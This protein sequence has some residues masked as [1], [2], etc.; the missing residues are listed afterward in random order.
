MEVFEDFELT[1]EQILH[2]Q[3]LETLHQS[4]NA[5]FDEPEEVFQIPQSRKRRRILSDEEEDEP[6]SPSLSGH[7]PPSAKWFRPRGKQPRI[8]PFT[9]IPG[10]KP[11][12]L[13]QELSSGEPGDFYS[14]LVN[15][16]MFQHIADQ[17]NI[18]AQQTIDKASTK[19][20]SRVKLWVPTDKEEIK[21]FFGLIIWMGIVKLPKVV[22]YWS[23]DEMLGQ[24]FAKKTMSRNRFEL[25]LRMLHFSDNTVAVKNDRLSKIRTVVDN[26]NHTFAF[27]FTPNEYLCVDESMIPF[28]G[29]IIFRQYNKSKRHKYGIKLF[30]LCTTPGYTTKLE[31]YAGKTVDSD[32]NTPT[33]VVLN[34]AHNLL[35]KGHTMFVDNWYTSLELAE[36]LI[37]QDTHLVG[38]L[39]KNRRNLPKDVMNANLKPG[40]FIAKENESGV[41]VMKW[42]DKRDVYLLS[43]KHSIG[44]IKKNNKRGEEKI[45]PKIVID[46]NKAKAAVDLSDQM[47]A[48]SSPLRKTLKWY[49]KLGIELLLNTAVVNARVLFQ[50]TTKKKMPVVD[51]RKSLSKYLICSTKENITQSAPRPKRQKHVLK[52]NEGSAVKTR[53]FCRDCYKKN[54]A[55]HGRKVAKN[56]TKKV[57]WFC[58]ICPDNPYLCR[59][60]FDQC[61]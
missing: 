22:D 58:P 8:I 15:E 32:C 38:T 56:K 10:L 12:A 24:D 20:K 44:F 21:R 49:K 2:L 1:Q 43:T 3:S 51:F 11:Y 47:T 55:L 31:V 45:K 35:G 6:V 33:N 53:K 34:L 14:L 60:C 30:K 28:R 42:K 23:V 54:V 41:T 40:E 17:T 18:F 13:R 19:A 39:R 46:Y 61:H 52:K 5:T 50:S 59:E 7:T 27:H 25:L 48:Y 26:L 9:E 36:K 29:R 4:E 16:Q 57:T 37:Q